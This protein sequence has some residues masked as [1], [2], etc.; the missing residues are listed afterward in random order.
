MQAQSSQSSQRV[1]TSEDPHDRIPSDPPMSLVLAMECFDDPKN[2]TAFTDY[3]VYDLDENSQ[4]QPK[5]YTVVISNHKPNDAYQAVNHNYASYANQ[6][7]VHDF[8][9]HQ[10]DQGTGLRSIA[11]RNSSDHVVST[12]WGSVTPKTMVAL[13]DRE[14]G[15][16]WKNK[17]LEEKYRAGVTVAATGAA[18]SAGQYSGPVDIEDYDL[19]EMIPEFCGEV[20]CSFVE[21]SFLQYID[22]DGK[23][24]D[25]AFYRQHTNEYNVEA[26]RA[27]IRLAPRILSD[28]T[29]MDPVESL[30]AT[31]A[32]IRGLND[33]RAAGS[34]Y[35]V[36]TDHRRFNELLQSDVC[37]NRYRSSL[38]GESA[39][40]YDT[41]RELGSREVQILYS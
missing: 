8:L 39:R 20:P 21:V 32:R 3:L 4:L 5:A 26:N 41:N 11:K 14:L 33:F 9:K 17:T 23:T 25:A 12:C 36:H 2:F 35:W 28:G 38:R 1:S 29:R 6:V 16:K 18:A 24:N 22:T 37:N 40:Q 13:V 34:R 15:R 27:G 19:E 31:A 7:P 10:K 30:T